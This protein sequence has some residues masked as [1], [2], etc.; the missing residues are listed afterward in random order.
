MDKALGVER[1][2]YGYFQLFARNMETMETGANSITV[3]S[4]KHLTSD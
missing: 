3:L 2:Y 1:L 4:D